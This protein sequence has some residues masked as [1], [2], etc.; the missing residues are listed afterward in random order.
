MKALNPGIIIPSI[1]QVVTMSKIYNV[2]LSK[3]YSTNKEI[4]HKTQKTPFAFS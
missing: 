3:F 2:L 1:Q 4:R